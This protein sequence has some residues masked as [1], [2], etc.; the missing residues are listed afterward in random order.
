MRRPRVVA[1]IRVRNATCPRFSAPAL[2]AARLRARCVFT[3]GLPVLSVHFSLGVA[4]HTGQ[5]TD[6]ICLSDTDFKMHHVS[7]PS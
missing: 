4:P 5:R 7:P 1:A 3:Q 2:A 6:K